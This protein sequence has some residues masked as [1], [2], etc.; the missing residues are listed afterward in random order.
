MYVLDSR[1]LDKCQEN[2]YKSRFVF[3]YFAQIVIC[4]R[5]AVQERGSPSSPLN[6]LFRSCPNTCRQFRNCTRRVVNSSRALFEAVLPDIFAGLRFGVFRLSIWIGGCHE[7]IPT[8]FYTAFHVEAAAG[9][10]A[11]EVGISTPEN[12]YWASRR[13]RTRTTTLCIPWTDLCTSNL[14]RVRHTAF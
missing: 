9:A 1:N 3:K 11:T 2:M 5:R 7:I 4:S 10:M 8:P 14:R 6:L 13:I 12:I